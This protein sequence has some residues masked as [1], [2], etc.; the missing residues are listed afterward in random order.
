MKVPSKEQ[1][2]ILRKQFPKGT[3]VEL[4]QMDDIQAPPVGTRGT[5]IWVDDIGDIVVAWDNGSQLNV[6]FGEDRVVLV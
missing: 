2:K 1:V 6:V 3:R 5:V 4:V